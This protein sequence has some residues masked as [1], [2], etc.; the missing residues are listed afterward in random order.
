MKKGSRVIVKG[1]FGTIINEDSG[2]PLM[3]QVFLDETRKVYKVCKYDLREVE[4]VT[5][6]GFWKRT[7]DEKYRISLPAE[8]VKKIGRRSIFLAMAEKVIVILFDTKLE[9]K[10]DFLFEVPIREN[11]KITI[12]QYFREKMISRKKVNLVGLGNRLEIR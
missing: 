11:N 12:P 3:F 6:R 9:E 7:I 2:N 5:V 10:Y 4:R 8:V 1:M